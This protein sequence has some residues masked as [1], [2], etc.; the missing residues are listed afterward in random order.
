MIFCNVVVAGGIENMKDWATPI[1]P[2]K[3]SFPELK[4]KEQRT[5][6]RVCIVIIPPSADVFLSGTFCTFT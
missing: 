5:Q 3:S 1:G 2:H 4:E 6:V